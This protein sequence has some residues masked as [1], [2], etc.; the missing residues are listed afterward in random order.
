MYILSQVLV[1]IAD[2]FFVLS[3]FQKRK[4]G[5]TLFLLLSNILFATHYLCLNAITGGIILCIDSAFL[6][7]VAL[8]EKLKKEKFTNIAVVITMVAVV[9]VTIITWEGAISILPMIAILAYLTGMMFSNVAVV[10]SGAALRNL[11]N[12]IYMFIIASYVGASLEICLMISG[13]VG[14]ILSYKRTKKEKIEG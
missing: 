2:I 3:M 7:V 13:I 5:L 6:V 9:C 1:V 12:I 4:L 10:K 8:L 14:A 11:F